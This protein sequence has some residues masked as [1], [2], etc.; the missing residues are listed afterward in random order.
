MIVEFSV[1]NFKS[2]KDMQTLNMTAA[3]IIS[4]YKE[5][6]KKNTLQISDKLSLLK[7]K[8]IYGANASGKS[9]I[10]NALSTFIAITHTSVKDNNTLEKLSSFRLST[11]TENEPTFFQLTFIVDNILYRYGFEANNKK[12]FSEWLFGCPGK[13]E[14]PFFT[15]EE[16]QIDVNKTQ[17][18]EGAKIMNLY[19]SDGND[20]ARENSLFLTTVSALNGKIS[21]ELINNISAIGVIPGLSVKFMRDYAKDSLKDQKLKLLI[22]DLLKIADTG[23]GNITR[24]EFTKEDLPKDAPSELIEALEEGK[25]HTIIVTEHKKFDA[26]Q[27]DVKS[28]FF[29][30]SDESEG[31]NKMFELSPFILDAIRHKRVLVIDEFDARFHPLLTKRLV[32][33]FNSDANEGAQ[34]IFATHDTNLLNAK[35]LRRDQ[36]CFVEKDKYG[37]SH[38]YDL[39]SFK[40][41]RN[42]ASLEKDYIAGKYGAIPFIGDFKSIIE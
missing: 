33:F 18:K 32:E 17:F 38:L 20:I 31:S 41:I 16:G 7:C 27:K 2:I 40:G 13:K 29:A 14:V 21:K 12:I 23:I 24:I 10:L 35:L 11:E 36:I 22:T 15:R 42:D 4:K 19:K 34:F 1:K 25:S 9:N 26:K 30:L 5:I 3:S 37:A 39:V 8:A 6:D 28:I